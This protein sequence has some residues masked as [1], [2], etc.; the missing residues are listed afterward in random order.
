MENAFRMDIPIR[1]SDID[2]LGHVNNVVYLAWIQ[3][4]SREH[5]MRIST[6]DIRGRYAWVVL[7]HQIDYHK[8]AMPGDQVTA[9]TWVGETAGFRSVRH[10]EIFNQRK[11]K[12]A[13]GKTTWCLIDAT[14]YKPVRV[15]EE[16]LACLERG[17]TGQ[18][19]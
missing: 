18:V 13:T 9:V 4:V 14:G 16:I 8:P 17:K 19:G 15:N 12:L 3:D 1:D 6:P 5:W 2:D 11:E 10:V 7:Q